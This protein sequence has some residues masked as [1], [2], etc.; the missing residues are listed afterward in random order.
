MGSLLFI[1]KKLLSNQYPNVPAVSTEI[2]NLKA[3][4]NLSKSTEHFLT[5]LHGEDEAFQHMLKTASG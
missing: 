2:I 5:D 3:I 4:L 1:P